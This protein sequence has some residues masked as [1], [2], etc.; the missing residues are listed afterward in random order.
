MTCYEQFSTP[1]VHH[2]K[3]ITAI[4]FKCEYAKKTFSFVYANDHIIDPVENIPDVMKK[5]LSV[6]Y[7]CHLS[8]RTSGSECNNHIEP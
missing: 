1:I 2:Y 4:Q 3:H 8:Q 5:A 6:C 7:Q